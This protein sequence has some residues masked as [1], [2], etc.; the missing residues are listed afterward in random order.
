M[1]KSGKALT[2]AVARAGLAFD[3]GSGKGRVSCD[4]G[5]DMGRVSSHGSSDG[6]KC[7]RQRKIRS[8]KPPLVDAKVA[9]EALYY[10][11]EW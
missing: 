5:S 3:D 7:D 11:G 10:T 2:A 4:G 6:R 8:A 9:E 1:A